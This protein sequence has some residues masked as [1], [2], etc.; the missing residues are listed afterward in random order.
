MM[1]IIVLF[2]RVDFFFFLMLRLGLD[3]HCILQTSSFSDVPNLSSW[4]Q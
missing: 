4:K 2:S 3:S 1:T